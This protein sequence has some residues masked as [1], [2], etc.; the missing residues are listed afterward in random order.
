[1]S[2][3]VERIEYTI[4]KIKPYIQRDGGNVEFVKFENGIVTVR[5]HGACVG[6]PNLNFT[7][8][9]GIEALLMDEVPEVK[10]VVLDNSQ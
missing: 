3:V 7:L 1:M 6:C 9:E 2:D 8:T 4:N 10:G 5:M